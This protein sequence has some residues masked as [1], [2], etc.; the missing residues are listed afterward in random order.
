M[1][2]CTRQNHRVRAA[3][4]FT[5]VELLVVIGIIGTLVGMLLPAVQRVREAGRRVSCMNNMKQM[6]LGLTNYE[7]ARRRFPP[8]AD[9]F[10]IPTNDWGRNHAWSSF[11]LPYLEGSEV[12]AK[13]DYKLWWNEPGGNDI[14][15][16]ITLPIYVCPSGIE[17][18]PGKQDY[19]GV[20]GW[21]IPDPD[22]NGGKSF[23]E[24]EKSGVLVRTAQSVDEKKVLVPPVA[25]RS[26]TDGLSK[27]LLV[28]EAVDRKFEDPQSPDGNTDRSVG[29]ARWA[30]GFNAVL[31][32]SR[33]INDPT[34]DG[35]R[36]LH[37]GG[38]QAVYADG[39]VAF[40]AESVDANA[41]VALVTKAGGETVSEGL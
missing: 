37:P 9:A 29:A 23:L 3:A 30:C 22:L 14:A 32:T 26:I 8:G 21:W 17:R 2:I 40:I 20:Y 1:A 12:A 28:V 34:I 33:S 35:F 41:L 6:G 24:A 19:G 7:A 36:S 11:I 10:P 27:T 31:L 25:A 18:F 13:I 15:S 4:G 5:L 39:H 38:I 16:D